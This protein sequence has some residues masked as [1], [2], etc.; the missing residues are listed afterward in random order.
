MKTLL[1]YSNIPDDQ[2]FFIIPDEEL[3][4]YWHEMLSLANGKIVNIH[5]TNEGMK[6]L[7]SATATKPEYCDASVD[8][9]YHCCLAKYK[10]EL[11]EGESAIYGP[12]S[13]VYVSGIFL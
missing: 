6:W 8:E 5:D 10:F 7:M 3:Q 12:F 11:A 9:V 2:Y 1:I 13:K 4:S